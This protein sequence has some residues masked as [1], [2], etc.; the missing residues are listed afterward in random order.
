M[1]KI[2]PQTKSFIILFGVVII[3]TYLSLG[4]WSELSDKRYGFKQDYQVNDQ[5]QPAVQGQDNV[6]AVDTSAWKTYSNPTYKV[7]FLYKPDWKVF[8]P[9]KKDGF[10]VIQIDP[11]AKFYN[12]KIYISPTDYYIMGGLPARTEPIGG[13]TALN[14]SNALF[15]IQA[16]NLY[17]T[18]DV[19]L[20]M[21]LVPDFAALV[22]SV[23][24]AD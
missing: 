22:R 13:Q 4:L 1:N 24:F 21:S 19:G 8:D 15:G 18:F 16:N 20:S 17:Y 10:T 6:P 2:S 14:V 9:I 23:K 12:I 7:S 3:G 5:Q 11:G